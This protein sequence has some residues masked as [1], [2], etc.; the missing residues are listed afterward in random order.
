MPHDVISIS[1]PDG[2]CPASVF[3]AND[4][5]SGDPSAPGVLFYMDAGGIRSAVR[6]M[7]QQLADAGYVVLLPDLYYRYGPYGLL[8]AEEVFAGDVGAILGPLMSTTS[9]A[10]AAEDTHA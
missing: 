4:G 5:A 1:M 7:A 8:I 3:T 10:I 9:N 2:D 6:R